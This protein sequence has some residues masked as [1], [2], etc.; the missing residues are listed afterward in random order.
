MKRTL[1][2]LMAIAGGAFAEPL[3]LSFGIQT[4]SS[5]SW[6]QGVNFTGLDDS[7]F[8]MSYTGTTGSVGSTQGTFITDEFTKIDCNFYSPKVQ[9]FSGTKGSYWQLGFEITASELVELNSLTF[10]L[11]G[12][13][14]NGDE[15]KHNSGSNFG[16][17]T[18]TLYNT[19][20]VALGSVT[21]KLNG[22]ADIVT[23]ATGYSSTATIKLNTP[24]TLDDTV[25]GFYLPAEDVSNDQQ[26]YL[27]LNGGKI[28]Y[29]VIPEPT[30][31]TL[32][33][34]ALCGLAARRRRS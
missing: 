15:W 17:V 20:N 21:V 1:I 24:I 29:S 2:A 18:L 22:S 9:F 25:T 28:G 33:L 26:G 31:A 4:T 16:D 6:S 19:K 8:S 34:L 30:T 12:R 5:A 23:D 27:A 32:S 11:D 13:T 7:I 14:G 10:D 3:T